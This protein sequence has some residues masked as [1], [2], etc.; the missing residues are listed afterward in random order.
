[1]FAGRFEKWRN[2]VYISCVIGGTENL[3]SAINGLFR[4]S[5]EQHKSSKPAIMDYFTTALVE[6]LNSGW[7]GGQDEVSFAKRHP[8]ITLTNI[9][10]VLT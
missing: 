8:E 2:T 10:A 5:P 9:S 3:L 4:D 6:K 7:S 1:M